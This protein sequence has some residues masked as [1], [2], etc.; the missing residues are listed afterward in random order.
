MG[1]W[2]ML[3]ARSCIK[4]Q[5]QPQ[6][7][8]RPI[9]PQHAS[10]AIVPTTN[11]STGKNKKGKRSV[12]K[13][14]GGL[15]IPRCDPTLINVGG[16]SVGRCR[17]VPIEPEAVRFDGRVDGNEIG[18]ARNTSRNIKYTPRYT[19]AWM[20]WLVLCCAVCLLVC[21]SLADA[22]PTFCTGT[23]CQ[24][25]KQKL[26]QD[27]NMVMT[28]SSIPR[29]L[30]SKR[31]LPSTSTYPVPGTNFVQTKQMKRNLKFTN[32]KAYG[33]CE[34]FNFSTVSVLR[35]CQRGMF[36]LTGHKLYANEITEPPSTSTV[37]RAPGCGMPSSVSIY[38]NSGTGFCGGSTWVG[39][40]IDNSLATDNQICYNGPNCTH[41]DGVT[42]NTV[43]CMCGQ[44]ICTADEKY[45]GYTPSGGTF[46]TVG[47]CN[48]GVFSVL[49]S[50][51]CNDP[52]SN[53]WVIKD[54]DDCNLGSTHLGYTGSATPG[55]YGSQ[56]PTGCVGQGN[57]VLYLQEDSSSTNCSIPYYQYNCICW[58][59]PECSNT[60]GTEP[61]DSTPCMCGGKICG[62]DA[63]PTADMYCI[64]ETM[65]CSLTP[66]QCLYTSGKTGNTGACTCGTGVSPVICG[67]VN[68]YCIRN[69]NF[70]G[71]QCNAGTYRNLINGVCDSCSAGLYNTETGQSD[72]SAC[73]PCS[74]G[75]YSF[76]VGASLESTC[77]NCPTGTATT[78]TAT[79]VITATLT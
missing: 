43:E 28:S 56:F 22:E 64:K 59:G 40:S 50:G 70:C 9:T 62:V 13:S 3:T 72:V 54:L 68:R 36:E 19:H 16:I 75:T 34:D 10:V 21:F 20:N 31:L 32:N 27:M 17:N 2:F 6:T 67:Q 7:T 39:G 15:I 79:S 11:P 45:C 5:K 65:Q 46:G 37:P 63:S 69:L 58:N 12:K 18:K 47:Q 52:E 66:R 78:I 38:L 49:H 76:A 57:D 23:E 26:K 24:T 73:V 61:I 71:P 51:Q 29:R 48:V 30:L 41:T 74:A 55:H 14:N 60:L 44:S 4:Q 53:R 33:C 35:D 25:S 77:Q 8:M 42:A 1:L